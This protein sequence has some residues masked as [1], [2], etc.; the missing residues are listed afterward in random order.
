MDNIG[1]KLGLSIAVIVLLGIWGYF[2]L[3][4]PVKVRK[5]KVELVEKKPI[6]HNTILMTFMLPNFRDRLHLKVGEH[7]EIS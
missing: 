5:M 3:R 4:K 7:L 6:N 2:A 1:M